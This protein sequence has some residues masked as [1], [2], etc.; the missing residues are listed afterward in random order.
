MDYS[1]SGSS[2]GKKT[3]VGCHS[4]LQRIFPTQGLNPLLPRGRQI[5]YNLSQEGSPVVPCASQWLLVVYLFHMFGHL[6]RRTNSLQRPWCQERLRAR[7]ER[8][9][10]GRD[11]WMA[12][13]SG[14]EFE[15]TQGDSEGHGS[16][17][18]CSPSASKEL[19]TT[20]PL[21]SNE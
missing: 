19:A 4:L 14:L 6:T 12:S 20:W 13:P 3:G 21:T 9:H 10:R 5:L 17:A 8:G 16:L 1:M 15:Q 2:P 11:G 7:R 18:C